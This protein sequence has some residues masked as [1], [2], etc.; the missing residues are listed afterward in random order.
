MP[1]LTKRRASIGIVTVAA[2]IPWHQYRI[3]RSYFASPIQ[4]RVRQPTQASVVWRH[5][6]LAIVRGFAIYAQAFDAR[7][8]VPPVNLLPATFRRAIPYLYSE[9]EIGA[10]MQAVTS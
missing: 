10:L 3:A 6:R 5:Q 1:V 7:H 8:E 9:T 2:N 4:I